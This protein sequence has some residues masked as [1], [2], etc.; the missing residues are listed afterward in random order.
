MSAPTRP[1]VAECWATSNQAPLWVAVALYAAAK[2]D[3]TTGTLALAP[4]TLAR[5][6]G[7]GG[8]SLSQAIRRAV[9][10]GW[11]ADGSSA[12]RLQLARPVV[13]P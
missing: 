11:L 9:R 13:Q 10:A 6:L 7:V 5:A 3:P 4:G 8:S 12:Y 1:T 2:A